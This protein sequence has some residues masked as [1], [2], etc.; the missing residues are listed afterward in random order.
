MARVPVHGKASVPEDR[1]CCYLHKLLQLIQDVIV[2]LLLQVLA[3]SNQVLSPAL[4]RWVN[5]L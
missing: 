1:G 4:Q 5:G 3:G 2:V